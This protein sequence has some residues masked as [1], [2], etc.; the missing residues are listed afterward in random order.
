MENQSLKSCIQVAQNGRK[1]FFFQ[2]NALFYP[3]NGVSLNCVDLC[4]NDSPSTGGT[5]TGYWFAAEGNTVVFVLCCAAALGSVC[6][7]KQVAK[8]SLT[9]VF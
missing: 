7:G 2:I 9:A 4:L 8:H 5:F 6:P 1:G 3:A